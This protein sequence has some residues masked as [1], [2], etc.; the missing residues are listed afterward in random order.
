VPA[1]YGQN[2]RA[3]IACS[4]GGGLYNILDAVS[5]AP[6][7]SSITSDCLKQFGNFTI[8][9]PGETK[10]GAVGSPSVAENACGVPADAIYKPLLACPGPSGYS[11]I[12]PAANTIIMSGVHESCLAQFKSLTISTSAD[13]RCSSAQTA[14]PNIIS[15]P[16]ARNV[17]FPMAGMQF[18]W[19]EAAH[20]TP[21]GRPQ[22]AYNVAPVAAPVRP[23]APLPALSPIVPPPLETAPLPQPMSYAPGQPI[24][25][26]DFFGLCKQMYPGVKK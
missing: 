4:L 6:V 12:D 26:A 16:G 21:V 5:G 9:M 3:V 11:I 15:N 22:G 24:P 7:M 19:S 14:P 13:P 20:F 17:T 18:P 8:A 2:G 1:G 25:V 23:P 10:C